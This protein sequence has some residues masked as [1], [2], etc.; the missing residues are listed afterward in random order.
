MFRLV[1]V[2]AIIGGSLLVFSVYK[3]IST[4][5]VLYRKP[6]DAINPKDAG[7]GGG[8]DRYKQP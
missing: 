6:K 8:Q 3:L 2:I 4:T 7:A 1:S 5:V